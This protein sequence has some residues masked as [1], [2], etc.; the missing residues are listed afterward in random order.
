M[1]RQKL[2]VERKINTAQ[3]AVEAAIPARFH[4]R[5]WPV[6]EAGLADQ[7]APA[8]LCLRVLRAARSEDRGRWTCVA[9]ESET[10]NPSPSVLE[11]GCKP[12]LRFPG[13]FGARQRAKNIRDPY[14]Y[15]LFPRLERAE[16][17]SDP[18]G[19]RI[20]LARRAREF[21]GKQDITHRSNLLHVRDV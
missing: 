1:Q 10:I 12:K 13:I 19:S 17:H 11:R 6:R 8:A 16:P 20:T 14:G 21:P 3:G 9:L 7:P 18:E 15:S 2:S 5:V 4:E